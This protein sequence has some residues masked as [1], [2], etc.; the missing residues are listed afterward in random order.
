[1]VMADYN[2]T[3]YFE[4]EVLKKTVISE[5]RMVHQSDRKPTQS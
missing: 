2:Y 3:E 4:K 5:E 1:M